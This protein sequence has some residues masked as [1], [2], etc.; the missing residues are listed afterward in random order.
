VLIKEKPTAADEFWIVVE[1]VSGGVSTR[2][3]RLQGYPIQ[4]LQGTAS[5]DLRTIQGPQLPQTWTPSNFEIGSAALMRNLSSAR[6]G[7]VNTSPVVAPNLYI[8]RN[9]PANYQAGI[10]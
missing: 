2:A 7:T 8:Y 4:G 10:V 5:V 6:T 3:I 9:T 1:T